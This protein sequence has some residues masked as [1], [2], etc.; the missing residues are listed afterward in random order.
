MACHEDQAEKIVPYL[1]V[2]GRVEVNAF[3]GPL[4]LTSDLFVLSFERLATPDQIVGMVLRSPHE[5][6]ARPLRHAVRRPLLER[7]DKSVLCQLLGGPDVADDASQPGDEPG[8]LD[9]PDCFDCALR[10]GDCCRISVPL[11]YG[12]SP[13]T[14]PRMRRP[15]GPRKSRRRRVPA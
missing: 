13:L 9:A 11:T 14:C 4:D 1:V 10:I 3:V 8:R 6:G 12:E 5:P 2:N 7:D 15:R